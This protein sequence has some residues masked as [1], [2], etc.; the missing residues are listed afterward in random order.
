MKYCVIG[1]TYPFRGGIA[2]FTTLLVKHLREEHEVRFIS[3]LKQYPRWLYPG[4]TAMDPSPES[5]VLQVPCERLLTPLDPL[6]WWRVYRHIRQDPPDA[7]ILQ[8]WTPFWS[9]M[10]FMLTRLIR[11]RTKTRIL[12]F[13]HHVV[14]PDGGILDWYLARRILKRGHAFI[15][16]SEDDFA[17]LRHAMPNATVR[18]ATH[19][20]PELLGHTPI[21]QA[22]ARVA[23][24]LSATEPVVLFFGFVR[25]YKGL[26]V[27]IDALAKA[28]HTLPIRLVIAG[29][30]WE[31]E[32]VYRA[33]V[34]RLG[35]SD[36]VRF[37]NAY[38]PNNDMATFFAAADVVALP[39]LEATQSGVVQWS[40]AF[41]KPI[42]ATSVGGLPEAVIHEKTGLLVPPNDA[43]ALADAMLHFFRDDK[44]AAFVDN[45]RATNEE[46]S[47][48]PL[49]NLIAELTR[50]PNENL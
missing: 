33:M 14:A 45:I 31:D 15:V 5:S 28:R 17:L 43:G 1:P 48:Q 30:F 47:W 42:I 38:V 46:R 21:S 49:I 27:L 9:P 50:R 8:W 13:C 7:V 16:M 39:Y 36:A 37:Y 11:L 25:R 20:P 34:A 26:P 24:G 3:Y 2:H 10:L 22:E 23:L 18:G 41:E 29:E 12:F 4:N 35:L 40:Y 6:T 32:E 44:S 19:P